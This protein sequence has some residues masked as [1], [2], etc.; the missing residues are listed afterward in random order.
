MLDISVSA[1]YFDS[2]GTWEFQP[3]NPERDLTRKG[4]VLDDF[5]VLFPMS[6]LDNLIPENCL[7]ESISSIFWNG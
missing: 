5:A 2:V 4:K 6:Q 7:L 1:C 3:P